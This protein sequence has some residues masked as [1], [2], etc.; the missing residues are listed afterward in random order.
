MTG[1]VPTFGESGLGD[2]QGRGWWGLAAPRGTPRPIIDKLNAEFVKLFSEPKFTAMLLEKQLVIPAA[3]SPED[4]AAFVKQDRQRAEHLI[5]LANTPRED[6]KP[7]ERSSERQVAIS[8]ARNRRATHAYI[9]PVA[10][11]RLRA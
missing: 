10:R 8:Q 11:L 4:F 3:T 7:P 9:A 5:K 6:Y 1:D 2:Y